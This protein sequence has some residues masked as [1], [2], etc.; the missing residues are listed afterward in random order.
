[1][2]VPE[3]DYHLIIGK[4]K[5]RSRAG[6]N[7]FAADICYVNVESSC[8]HYLFAYTFL[9]TLNRSDSVKKS[10]N[11]VKHFQALDCVNI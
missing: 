2:I 8:D 5:N 10:A 1:M 6:P 11:E 4:N 9:M 7:Q 3:M